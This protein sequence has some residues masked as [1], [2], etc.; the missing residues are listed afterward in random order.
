MGNEADVIKNFCESKSTSVD[1]SCRRNNKF[2][3]LKYLAIV[4]TKNKCL[5]YIISCAQFY[6]IL[7]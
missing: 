6:K 7:W 1:Y 4:S 3:L 2:N 5:Y